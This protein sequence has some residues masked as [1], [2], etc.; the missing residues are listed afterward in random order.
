MKSIYIFL[1]GFLLC[2]G[3]LIANEFYKFVPFHPNIINTITVTN[4]GNII[5][6]TIILSNIT[7]VIYDKTVITQVI[8]LFQEYSNYSVQPFIF[9]QS[10]ENLSVSLYKRNA[11][12][13]IQFPQKKWIVSMYIE[14]LN[15]SLGVSCQYNILWGIYSGLYF[16]SKQSLKI[17]SSIQF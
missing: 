4:Q 7:K 16:D 17:V 14:P 6:P 9:V 12:Y 5:K 10:N 2:F 1:S 8:Y 3:M 11:N 15:F 13:K